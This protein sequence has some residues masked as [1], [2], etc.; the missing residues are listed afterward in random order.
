MFKGTVLSIH[1]AASSGD[2][3]TTLDRVHAVAGKGLEGDRNFDAGHPEAAVTLIE[4]E[5]LAA[6]ATDY[7]VALAPADS[8]RNILVQDVPLNHLVGREFTVGGVRL[9]GTELCEPCKYLAGKTDPR[10]LPGLIHRGGLRAAILSDGDI[11]AGD[12]VA[13][14]AG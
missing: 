2:P 5:A 7:G 4:Q 1:I 10:V 8:R 3:L 13:I 14:A 11:C 6:L 12:T 9:R